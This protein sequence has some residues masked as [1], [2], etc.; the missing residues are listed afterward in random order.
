MFLMARTKSIR[1][2]LLA[3]ALAAFFSANAH[4]QYTDYEAPRWRVNGFAGFDLT[5]TLQ[6]QTNSTIET[7]QLFPLGDLRLIGDGF[8]VDPKFLHINA[9]FDYQKGANT[10]ERGDLGMG[11]M[12]MAVSTAFLPNSHMPLRVNYTRTN[13]GVTGLGLDQNNDDSRLDVQ[14]DIFRNHLPHIIAS[15]QD[16]SSTVHVPTSFADHT[17]SERALNLGASDTWKSWQW[18]GSFSAGSGSTT[19]A[20][21]IIQD[22]TFDNSTRAGFFNLFRAFWDNK[23]HLR[24][25]NRDVWRDEHLQGDGSTSNSELTNNATFDVQLNPKVSLIAGYAFS[26]VAF[27][28]S[29]FATQLPGTGPI[30]LL[31]LV[32][33]HSNSVTGRVDY[34][35]FNWLR[36]SQD[37]RES[38]YSPSVG[39]VESQL[40]YTDTDSTIEASHRWRGFDFMGSYTGRFQIDSTSLDQTPNSWSNSFMGRVAWGDAHNLRV[41]ASVQDNHLNL[42]EQIGGF[43]NETR[44]GFEA[45]THR[46]RSLRLRVSA[47]DSQVDLL[48][49]SGNTRSKMVTYSASADHRLFTVAYTNTFLDGAGALFPLGLID[50]Q[51]LVV[52]LPIGQLVATPLLNRTTHAQSVSF[53]GRPRRRLE[54]SLAWRTE[55]TVL[56]A[57]EETF[58]V[59]QADARYRL[60]KFTV[61]GG[62][63]RNLND[64]TIITGVNG[65]RLALWYFRIGRDFKLL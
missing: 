4:A 52:P 27:E 26:Q 15:F 19:G 9:A 28:N 16:Y 63:G 1:A 60:G 7:G 40:S 38:F 12:N 47:E 50:H 32:A 48:N 33:S 37:V 3:T 22:N 62:Y 58:N 49:V 56:A 35:P 21:P 18:S 2:L 51:F 61:E 43:T 8:L 65:T 42:V 6:S 54:V 10:S 46:I 39:V 53:L 5:H 23:A 44:I 59:L 36:F 30:Q 55:D 45:E 13:H 41:A 31:S 14:W 25:E 24:V 64:V 34:H 11:G 57:S 20:S 17:F 29:S